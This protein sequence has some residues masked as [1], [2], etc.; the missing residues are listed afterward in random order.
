MISILPILLLV[1]SALSMPAPS[2]TY[3]WSPALA[4]FYSIVD[5][6]IQEARAAPSFPQAP[7]CDLSKASMPVA[8]TPL[9]APN[10]GDI[11]GHVAIGRGVQVHTPQAGDTTDTN[12]P[13]ELH[14]R[15]LL[16]HP[17]R[18][19][20]RRLPLQRLLHRRILP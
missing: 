11:L 3:E 12:K 10:M 16:R 4:E 6:H 17:G 14:M 8:P 2:T 19:R 5:R 7:A 9:P 1:G 20:C 18:H 13:I 15:Q